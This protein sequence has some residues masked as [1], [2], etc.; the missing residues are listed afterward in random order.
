MEGRDF[1]LADY[2]RHVVYMYQYEDKKKIRNTGFAKLEA[3]NGRCKISLHMRGIHTIGEA[4]R[5][6][7][8]Q[9]KQ[10]KMDMVLL[11]ELLSQGNAGQADFQ[12]VLLIQQLKEAGIPLECL[13]GIY[14]S[15]GNQEFFG[16]FD[17]KEPIFETEESKQVLEEDTQIHAAELESAQPDMESDMRPDM[18]P[19]MES[20][21]NLTPIPEESEYGEEEEPSEQE[22]EQNQTDFPALSW[23]QWMEQFAQ[24]QPFSYGINGSFIKME[25]K[26]LGGLSKEQWYLANNSFLL[27]GYYNYRYL[28]LM[29]QNDSFYLL[30]PGNY[31]YQERMMA[32]MFGFQDFLPAKSQEKRT[33]S[34]GYWYR[35]VDIPMH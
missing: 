6:Y 10:E 1:S 16:S 18:G 7:L 24:V 11:G 33:G 12:K 14:V 3:R 30:V 13:A 22:R 27:H 34:F 15:A 26:D 25:P 32:N 29:R 5:I 28:L 19:D 2:R 31:Y 23:E 21:M 17:G 8:Y 9:W 20:D 35:Q 4:C